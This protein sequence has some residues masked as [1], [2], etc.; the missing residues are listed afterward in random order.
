ML[1]D[2]ANRP[3]VMG[4]LNLTPDS[5]SDGGQFQSIGA[6][7]QHARQM[8]AAGAGLIDVGGES[9]RPGSQP[10]SE[11]EQIV[12][13][14]P[15]IR[16]LRSE[17]PIPISIDTTRAAVASAA[18]DAGASIVND[19]SA[20]LDDPGMLA[21]VAARKVKI[22]LMHMQGTPA[23]MQINPSYH[24][25]VSE[26]KQFLFDRITY[27]RTLGVNLTD[28]LVD[29]GVGFGKSVQ[30]NLQLLNRLKEFDSLGC[31]LVVGTSRK[32]FI[33]SITGETGERLLGT[34]ATVAWAAA[35]GAAIVRVHDVLA[36]HRVVTMIR[37][38]RQSVRSI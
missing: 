27:A 25:V 20:G 15:V 33:G 16:A 17:F 12:R 38:I 26:V 11:A 35:N 31:P 37:Q 23:T 24:D 14:V 19:I 30:H 22:I 10:V 1:S 13:V 29:P 34:A 36:M 9:T 2:V 18:L 8:A 5:F 28:V 32:G 3:V 6:A 7:L 4:I 21:M